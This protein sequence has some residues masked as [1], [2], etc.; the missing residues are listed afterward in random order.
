MITIRLNNRRNSGS[1]DTREVDKALRKLKK[2]MASSGILN[3]LKD[4]QHF[5]KPGDKKRS[6]SAK[7]RVRAKREKQDQDNGIM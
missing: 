2:S 6:K 3:E 1:G 5:I 7:A 4:R